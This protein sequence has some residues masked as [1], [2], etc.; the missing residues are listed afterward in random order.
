VT[1][2]SGIRNV[3]ARGKRKLCQ[4]F[5]HLAFPNLSG[6]WYLD[7]MFSKTQS[8][9]GHLTAQVFTNGQGSD[10]FCPIKSKVMAG[11]NTLMPFIQE[12]GIPRQS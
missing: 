4:K 7:T 12:V 10:H 1:A 11:P 2:Q 8:V 3:L 9:R 6:K 5:D